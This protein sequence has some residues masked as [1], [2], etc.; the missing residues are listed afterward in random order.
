MACML[1]CL[2]E[3]ILLTATFFEIHLKNIYLFLLIWLHRVL[4]VACGIFRRGMR[5]LSCGM[6]DPV[7]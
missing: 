7:P 5:T 3:N 4:V 6:W 1:K 2:E